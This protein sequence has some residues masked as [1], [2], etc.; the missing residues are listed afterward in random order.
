VERG[1]PVRLHPYL[2]VGCVVSGQMV[3]RDMDLL[4]TMGLTALPRKARTSA[5][6]RRR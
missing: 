1:V 4:A 5:P 2:D 6:V 3:H